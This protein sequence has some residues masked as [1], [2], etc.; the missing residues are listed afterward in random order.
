MNAFRQLLKAAGGHPPVGTWIMSASPLVAEATGHAGFDWGVIDMEHAPL[1]LMEVVQLLQAVAST[2]MVPIV[3]VPWNE[4]VI[5]KRVLDAG[6]A[7]VMFPFVQD[8]AEAAR[9]YDAA[10][11]R[12][13]ELAEAMLGLGRAMVRMDGGQV[14]PEALALFQRA[15]ERLNDPTPWVYQAMAAMQAGQDREAGRF[16]GEA[17]QRMSPDDP[18]RQMAGQFASGQRPQRRYTHR[19]DVRVACDA[20]ERVLAGEVDLGEAGGPVAGRAPE[21]A[22]WKDGDAGL[23]EQ[24]LAQ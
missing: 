15:G 9:A 7:T 17:L 3:R 4:A 10:L 5:V 14:S 24:T 21:L 23:L 11:R 6:A 2:K 8:A 20:V 19:R 13:P 18:R 1:D 22:A 16:W 12:D